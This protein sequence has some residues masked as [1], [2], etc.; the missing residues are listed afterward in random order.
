[1]I[2]LKGG[3][4][5]FWSSPN[6]AFGGQNGIFDKNVVVFHALHMNYAQVWYWANLITYTTS[7]GDS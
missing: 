4:K 1:M 6:F 3:A 5:N 2:F 7:D